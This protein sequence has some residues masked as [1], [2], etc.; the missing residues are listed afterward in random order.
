[1]GPDVHPSAASLPGGT[2]EQLTTGG[3]S[4][5]RLARLVRAN[6]FASTFLHSDQY[7]RLGCQFFRRASL[8]RAEIVPKD[9]CQVGVRF[10]GKR[11]PEKI[12]TPAE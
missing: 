10:N 8:P 5:H 11:A 4:E 7:Y 2:A 12:Y 6:D 3:M 9:I 1:M